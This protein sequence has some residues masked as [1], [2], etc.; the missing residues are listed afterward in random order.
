MSK[1]KEFW[2]GDAALRGQE[3]RFEQQGDG[4]EKQTTVHGHEY[5]AAK[6][7]GLR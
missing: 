5:A 2:L 6:G 4:K 3:G 1:W 7:R